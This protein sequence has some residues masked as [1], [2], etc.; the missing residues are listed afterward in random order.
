MPLLRL[1]LLLLL[2]AC[3]SHRVR[4]DGHLQPINKPATPSATAGGTA[5]GN[6]Q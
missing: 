4:C 5:A 1:M 6:P 3:T 2:A